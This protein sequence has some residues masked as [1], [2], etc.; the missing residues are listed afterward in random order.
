MTRGLIYHDAALSQIETALSDATTEIGDHVTK[1]LD[2]VNGQT[3]AWTAETPSR[4][5]QHD[6]EQR[7]RTGLTALTDALDGVRRAVADH[8]ER[9]HDAEV[10]NVAI[11]G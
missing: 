11:V 9:C 2:T 4:Q 5:A 10:E 7:L 8:H 3:A 6:Y 1:I